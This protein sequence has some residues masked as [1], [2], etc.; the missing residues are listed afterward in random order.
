MFSTAG[1]SANDMIQDFETTVNRNKH[2]PISDEVYDFRFKLQS[3]ES[4]NDLLYVLL[5]PVEKNTIFY[6]IIIYI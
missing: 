5:V 2:V 3:N 4:P 1:S 6:C